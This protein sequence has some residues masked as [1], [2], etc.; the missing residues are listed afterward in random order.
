MP[1]LGLVS[2]VLLL[3]SACPG[4]RFLPAP[5]A[6]AGVGCSNDLG[7]ANGLECACGLCA[8]PGP[9]DL[10]PSCDVEP[11]VEPCDTPPSSCWFSCEDPSVTGMAS[12]V[13]GVETCSGNGV[14]PS[15]CAAADC[16]GT[17]APGEICVNGEFRC[18]DGRSEESGE[19]YT[20][21]CEG[22]PALC[23]DECGGNET[24]WARCLAD[25]FQ[26][27]TG[28]PVE[29]C[30]ACPGAAPVCVTDCE[31]KVAVANA[32]CDEQ[33]GVFSCAHI[34]GAIPVDECLDADAGDAGA[35]DGGAADGG[36][37]DGGMSTGDGGAEL[38]DA[39]SAP[40]ASFFDAGDMD[41]G[42]LPDIGAPAGRDAGTSERV[43]AGATAGPGADGGMT[44]TETNAGD[45]G[46]V[47][48]AG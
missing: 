42:D 2:L 41:A 6:Q 47:R 29:S 35:T 4:A 20:S 21:G 24:F 44:Q 10:P 27:E 46:E 36:A 37:A 15:Q 7:C 33:N 48:D 23:T 8:Q 11:S 31:T 25:R 5:G 39:G 14:H 45:A 30:P 28:V 32:F 40:D 9:V 34:L 22:D 19:C 26:C 38:H 12:C 43:D 16:A 18:E 1:R 3:G 17:P 13:N